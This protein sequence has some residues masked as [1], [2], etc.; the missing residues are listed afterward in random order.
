[1]GTGLRCNADGGKHESRQ[2]AAE[3]IYGQVKKSYRGRK[4]VRVRPAMRLEALED[5]KIAMPRIGFLWTVEH[6]FH[7]AGE[8]DHPTWNS[9]AGSSHLGYGEACPTPACPS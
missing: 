2:E 9:R 1:M 5:L 8:S 4:L 6:R 7:R 3:L